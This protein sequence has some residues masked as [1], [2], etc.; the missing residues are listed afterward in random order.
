MGALIA[1]DFLLREPE[2]LRGAIISGAPLAPVGA[3]TPFLAL[4]ARTF[5]K[6]WPRFSLNLGLN[7]KAISRDLEVTK[8][9]E[10]DPLVHGKATVRWGAE[11]LR[12]IEWVKAH[13]AEVR[14]PIMVIHGGADPI[15]SAAG[16][17]EF[18]A[19]I[20][21]A[22]KELRIY[23]GSYH[24]IHND[25]DQA[26]VMKDVTQWLERHFNF[27]KLSDFQVK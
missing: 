25:L 27:F 16:S 4:I 12:A 6:A 20:S 24:E 9:Y 23:P 13:A 19:K 22:D 7:T 21:F 26:K 1:L 15:V 2:G 17:Q 3:G 11:I 14:I 18:F 10:A 8:A 5:S